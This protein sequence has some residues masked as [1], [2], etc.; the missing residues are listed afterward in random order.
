M[1]KLIYMILSFFKYILILWIPILL[2]EET[3]L[4]NYIGVMGT[5]ICSLLMSVLCLIIYIKTY[6]KAI[7]ER[8]NCYMYNIINAV[9]L[10][11]TNLVL[12]YLFIS[13]I[14]LNLFHQ[15][16]GYGWDCFLFGIE[17]LL[18]GIEYAILSTIILI[19]WL[20]VRLIRF[21][22]AKRKNNL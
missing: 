1:K 15:C 6:K 20:I 22:S 12:G 3:F 21:L 2:I 13:L 10:G 9:L 7:K 4:L 14:D 19:V 5:L 18:I 11:I 16:V 17:Y 8:I